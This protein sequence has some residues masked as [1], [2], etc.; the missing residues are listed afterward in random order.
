M[1]KITF[2]PV[3]TAV[4]AA[5]GFASLYQMPKLWNSLRLPYYIVNDDEVDGT[6]RAAELGGQDLPI[7]LQR[8]IDIAW[9][10]IPIC[11]QPR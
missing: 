2:T 8:L 10:A 3:L 1:K 9:H 4:A 11:V 7:R 6:V 5:R